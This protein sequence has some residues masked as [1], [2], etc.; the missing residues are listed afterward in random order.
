MV[1]TMVSCFIT[2]FRRFDTVE[3]GVSMTRDSRSR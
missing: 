3:T 2:T 1:A